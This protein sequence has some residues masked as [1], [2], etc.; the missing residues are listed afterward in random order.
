VIETRGTHVLE[1]ARAFDS[2]GKA[3]DY[4]L[5]VENARL[6]AEQRHG[7]SHGLEVRLPFALASFV[8]LCKSE[9]VRAK[10]LMLQTAEATFLRL[11]Q[12]ANESVNE[13]ADAPA[14]A[15]ADAL[16]P[17]VAEV[18]SALN[19]AIAEMREDP[20]TVRAC[21][22]AIVRPLDRP[23]S[24]SWIDL[25]CHSRRHPRLSQ[26]ASVRALLPLPSGRGH[27]RARRR[28]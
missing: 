28:P 20:Q 13:S 25:E 23:R 26:R 22:H 24:I 17:A 9:R 8:P 11:P 10:A 5:R 2:H 14:P 3:D 27:R 21:Y 16:P 12:P 6:R 4:G 18:A 1:R 19:E 7:L 15:E